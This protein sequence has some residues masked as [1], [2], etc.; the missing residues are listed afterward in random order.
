MEN[1]NSNSLYAIKLDGEEAV[2][3]VAKDYGDAIALWRDERC[4]TGPEPDNIRLICESEQLVV[5]SQP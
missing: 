4:P 3:V 5:R 1:V 2:Y